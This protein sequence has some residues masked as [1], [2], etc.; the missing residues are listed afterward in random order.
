MNK[1]DTNINEDKGHCSTND[2]LRFNQDDMNDTL[3]MIDLD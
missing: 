2:S 3:E 1:I